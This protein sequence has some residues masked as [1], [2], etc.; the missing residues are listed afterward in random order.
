MATKDPEVL[1]DTTKQLALRPFVAITESDTDK[2]TTESDLN[3]LNNHL[4]LCNAALPSVHSIV[5]LCMLSTTVTKL[6]ETRR[7]VKKLAYGSS[8]ASSK[9]YE[10]LE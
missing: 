10:V 8:S 2:L 6:I 3:I 5:G 1:H 7:K 9:V 4:E